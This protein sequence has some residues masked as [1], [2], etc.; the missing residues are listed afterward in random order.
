MGGG[1]DFPQYSGFMNYTEFV[2]YA[3]SYK[4]LEGI[5]DHDVIQMCGLICEKIGASCRHTLS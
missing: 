4:C 3:K 5:L 2:C 1:A